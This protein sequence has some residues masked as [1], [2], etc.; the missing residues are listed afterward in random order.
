MF[1]ATTARSDFW[2]AEDELL[3]LGPWCTPYD[4]KP[5]WERLRGRMLA[6]PW[7]DRERLSRAIA[8]C[9]E[10]S[11]RLLPL[12]ADWLNARHG[13][14]FS[15]RYWR[16]LLGLWLRYH[17]QQLY[18]HYIHATDALKAH[19]G[20]RTLLSDEA[21][22]RT[23]ADFEEFLF[24]CMRTDEYHLQ[25]YSS[26]FARLGNFPRRRLTSP[27]SPLSPYAVGE[28]GSNFSLSLIGKRCLPYLSRLV[29]SRSRC[30]DLY[31]TRTESLH[32]FCATGGKLLPYLGP[33]PPHAVM[34]DAGSR[35]GLASLPARDE[36]ERLL[37]QSLP[38]HLPLLYLES[39][40]QMRQQSLL[41]LGKRPEMI[42]TSVGWYSNEATKFAMAEAAE[43]G[44][45]LWGV[46]HGGGPGMVRYHP[47]EAHELAIF[48][49][50]FTWG[51]SR[52]AKDPKLA[53]WPHPKTSRSLP[54][55]PSGGDVLFL[56][57][58]EP[59][60]TTR[61][62]RGP[63]GTQGLRYLEWQV[64]FI[65][66]LPEPVF[67]RLRVRDYPD[68][69]GWAHHRRLLDRFPGLR[70]D[71]SEPFERS[72]AAASLVVCDHPAT[73]MLETIPAGVPTLVFWDPAYY[74]ARPQA[75]PFL[76]ALR[77]QGVLFDSPKAAARE[78]ETALA[79]PLGWRDVPERRKAAEDFCRVYALRDS[80][81]ARVWARDIASG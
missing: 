6:N 35:A 23:P 71:G 69:M 79:D 76:S 20:A 41:S 60:S 73:T 13:T 46:Q 30:S 24:L 18:D 57:T 54:A 42:L 34:P 65:S 78:V 1:L 81:W 58:T 17:I 10:V 61:L 59:L 22:Y 55:R 36:F 63:L 7:D 5:E 37:V 11:E 43:N 67:R 26:I 48:D 28:S 9:D 64:D 53:D 16:I 70:F 45:R 72:V 75:E 77:Q 19:P 15:T 56:T 51:W 32:L 8:Y 25:L 31:L 50:Y 49:R 52:L 21:D 3:F 39:Y 12:L 62:A 38:K 27:E 80:D 2:D 4:R 66:A 14:K 74:E 40:E 68:D 33:R 47:T 44:T 29:I